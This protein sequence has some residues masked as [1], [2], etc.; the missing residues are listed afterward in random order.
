MQ[1]FLNNFMIFI[2]SHKNISYIILFLW[3]MWESTFP[4]SFFI[5]W[6]V[7]FLA[8]SILAWYWILNIYIIIPILIIWW[9]LWDNLSYFLWNRYWNSFLKYLRNHK[10]LSKILTKKRY[11]K[12]EKFFQEK[13]WIWIIIARLSWP[14]A[15]VTPFVAWSFW[16]KYRIFLK[17]DI[18]WATLWISLFIIIWYFFGKNF[19]LIL[20]YISDYLFVLA[21]FLF[22]ILLV[23]YFIKK[24][25][26]TIW[27]K[28]I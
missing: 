9:I 16:L 20:N 21:I 1:E 24:Y 4:V 12:I 28:N 6:E 23:F 25:Y 13:W 22:I 26:K 11:N 8:G 7:F 2:E 10:Y 18:F 3:A 17:Y 19:N 14:L 15:R 5:Y 27:K